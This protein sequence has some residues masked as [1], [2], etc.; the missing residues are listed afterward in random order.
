MYYLVINQLML[1]GFTMKISSKINLCIEN[2]FFNV[3]S[4]LYYFFTL[5]DSFPKLESC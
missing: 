2:V 5:V 3:S 4:L 1:K